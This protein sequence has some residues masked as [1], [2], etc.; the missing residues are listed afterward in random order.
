MVLAIP[1]QQVLADPTEGEVSVV[2]AL[3][4]GLTRDEALPWRDTEEGRRM[5]GEGKSPGV[6]GVAKVECIC[7]QGTLSPKL[8]GRPLPTPV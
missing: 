5:G 3:E 2:K 6:A 8:H 7:K 4:V 1:G